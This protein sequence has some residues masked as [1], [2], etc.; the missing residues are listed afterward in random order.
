MLCVAVGPYGRLLAECTEGHRVYR[1]MLSVAGTR[2]WWNSACGYSL[3]PGRSGSTRPSAFRQTRQGLWSFVS[4]LSLLPPVS[5]CSA[6]GD[7]VD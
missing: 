2:G 7:D 5:T 6:G 1:L 3:A 4:G